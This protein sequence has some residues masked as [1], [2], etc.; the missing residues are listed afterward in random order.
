M[1]KQQVKKKGGNAK[2]PMAQVAE[3]KQAVKEVLETPQAIEPEVDESLP[4][5]DADE[6]APVVDAVAEI[7]EAGTAAEVMERAVITAIKG[8]VK[9]AYVTSDGNCFVSRNFY[10]ANEHV[11]RNEGVKLFRVDYDLDGDPCGVT[12]MG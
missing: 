2:K 6:F 12:K 1:A 9:P 10:R 3:F 11:N 4:V 7:L 5:M 8:G